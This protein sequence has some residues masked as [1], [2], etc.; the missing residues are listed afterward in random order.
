ML[1]QRRRYA[2]NN[3]YSIPFRI[4]NLG[5]YYFS[6]THRTVRRA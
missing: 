6:G 1:K 5:G 4:G 3:A 2:L